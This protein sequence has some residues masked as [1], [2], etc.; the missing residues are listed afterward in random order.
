M[1]S[2]VASA[3][4]IHA[5]AKKEKDGD[6]PRHGARR[7]LSKTLSVVV[8]VYNH[9]DLLAGALEAILNQSVKPDEI[10][11]ID[12]ESSDKTPDVIASFAGRHS[13][14]RP[15]RNPTNI[16]PLASSN[17]GLQVATGEF[18]GFFA[19][20]DRVYPGIFEKLIRALR[21]HSG[22]AYATGISRVVSEA[23]REIPLRHA[24]ISR[25]PIFI[26]PTDFLDTHLAHGSFV[27]ANTSLFRR[28]LVIEDGGFRH[29]V[30]SHA[31]SFLCLHLGAK[32][33]MCVVPEILGEWRRTTAGFSASYSIDWESNL[34]VFDDMTRV[35]R[36]KE[37]DY[38]SDRFVRRWQ[39]EWICNN[40]ERG[41]APSDEDIESVLNSLVS[42]G[43]L[44]RIFLQSLTSAPWSRR[45]STKLYRFLTA[46]IRQKRRVLHHKLFGSEISRAEESRR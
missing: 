38:F 7:G 6:R 2:I 28:R 43:I 33:G 30:G 34:K 25:E 9:G 35:M 29:E 14:I 5:I 3:L 10:I 36:G 17:L 12:D 44:D 20:D 39:R 13:A 45:Y 41:G 8:P 18:I 21:D 16:G 40:C 37:R 42:P 4:S 23:G 19:A 27:W 26:P 32:Y 11:V 15:M 24:V 1:K 46:D 22:A 31:D